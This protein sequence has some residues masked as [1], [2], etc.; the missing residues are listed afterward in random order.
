MIKDDILAKRVIE[1]ATKDIKA[2]PAA[3]KTVAGESTLKIAT[4]LLNLD[5]DSRP[6]DAEIDAFLKDRGAELTDKDRMTDFYLVAYRDYPDI[7]K[8]AEN[9]K[10][11]AEE[12]NPTDAEIKAF[13]DKNAATLFKDKKLE[14]VKEQIIKNVKNSK[15]EAWLKARFAAFSAEIA[16]PV[17]AKSTRYAQFRNA[18]TANKLKLDTQ[19]GLPE[20]TFVGSIDMQ[21]KALVEAIKGLKAIDT[22][23]ALTP[24]AGDSGDHGFAIAMKVDNPNKEANLRNVVANILRGEKALVLFEEKIV[25]TY[26]DKL[27]GKKSIE[28]FLA[29]E[30]HTGVEENMIDPASYVAEVNAYQ[31]IEQDVLPFISEADGKLTIEKPAK[32]DARL[33]NWY[34]REMADAAAKKRAEEALAAFQKDLKDGKTLEAADTQKRF[35]DNKKT[36]SWF[37]AINSAMQFTYQQMYMSRGQVTPMM[38]KQAQF[39]G[40]TSTGSQA[41]TPA[42]NIP[43]LCAELNKLG[44]NA[45]LPKAIA[46]ERQRTVI[47]EQGYILI[48]QVKRDLPAGDEGKQKIEAAENM[49]VEQLK[50]KAI[51]TLKADL[52]AK[53]N[54]KLADEIIPRTEAEE[55]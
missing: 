26:Q 10:K 23:T 3:I 51:E 19:N 11:L 29:A 33:L 53:S 35:V 44:D 6:S 21:Q 25:K 22:P 20:G 13:F 34:N 30:L 4:F 14:D 40:F 32:T 12:I 24:L 55:K 15:A 17:P 45:L 54:T 39:Y 31:T 28:E 41:G 36:L 38:L 42:K 16:K 46:F 52:L 49:I 50:N 1:N 48:Y 9:D 18:A 43:E 47:P 2:D 5:R 37:N 7:F 27:V 8:A